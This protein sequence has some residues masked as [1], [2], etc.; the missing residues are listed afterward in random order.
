MSLP[1]TPEFQHGICRIFNTRKFNPLDALTPCD[2]VLT[3]APGRPS[4]CEPVYTGVTHAPHSG[5]ERRAPT[6]A[7]HQGRPHPPH[8]TLPTTA[9]PPPARRDPRN[10]R[11]R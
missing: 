9:R 1:T 11:R 8:V 6:E 2:C 7:P 3:F 4:W 10:L 5:H